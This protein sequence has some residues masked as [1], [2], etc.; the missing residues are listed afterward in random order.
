MFYVDY[1]GNEINCRFTGEH[2]FMVDF[3]S[4]IIQKPSNYFRQAMQ[5]SELLAFSYHDVE[6]LY[7]KSNA[8][9]HFGRK[10][11]EFVYMQLNERVEM[12]QFLSPEQRYQNLL[13][14]H[15]E[16]FNKVSQ[17]HLSLNWV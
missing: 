10:M 7:A 6:D 2:H 13:E 15:P 11:E 4:F 17:F 5:D 1:E 12:F 3:Q 14:N 8:W 16:L 9:R